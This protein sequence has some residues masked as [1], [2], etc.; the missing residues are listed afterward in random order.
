MRLFIE[1]LDDDMLFVC[2]LTESGMKIAEK[3]QTEA[4]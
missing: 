1:I 3:D 4:A 2:G